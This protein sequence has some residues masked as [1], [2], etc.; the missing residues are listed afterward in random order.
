MLARHGEVIATDSGTPDVPGEV[1]AHL[2]VDGVE[3][4]ERAACVVK[5]PG[6]PNEAPVIARRA[7]A[8]CRCSASS[9]WPG[10]CCR[11]ASWR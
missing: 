7:S 11:T 4:L 1:E 5:S 2:G 8:G 9:S 10:G 6:V 3:L